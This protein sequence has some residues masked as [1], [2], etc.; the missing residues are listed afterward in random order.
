MTSAEDRRL[1][2]PLPHRDARPG[3]QRLLVAR[4]DV[5][6][7]VRFDPEG[8]LDPP[9]RCSVCSEMIRSSAGVAD[10]AEEHEVNGEDSSATPTISDWTCPVGPGS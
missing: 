10:H 4:A 6:Q 9:R 3:S 8:E 1:V 2:F 5:A 7:H